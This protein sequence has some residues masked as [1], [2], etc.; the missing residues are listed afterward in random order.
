MHSDVGRS[1]EHGAT[2]SVFLR[3]LLA[4][5][6]VMRSRSDQIETPIPPEQSHFRT[7]RIVAKFKFKQGLFSD[8][9]LGHFII[10]G[11]FTQ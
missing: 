1:K 2:V 11:P 5:L 7:C 6:W 10:F 9:N 8:S 4:Q 3:L